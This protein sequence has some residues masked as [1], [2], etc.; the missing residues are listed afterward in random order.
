MWV[1]RCEVY[2]LEIMGALGADYNVLA[3]M[4]VRRGTAP[5]C[6]DFVSH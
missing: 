5:F 4:I 6:E 1:M 2:L 3:H